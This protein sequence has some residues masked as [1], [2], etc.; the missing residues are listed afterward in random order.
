MGRAQPRAERD[1][2]Q[3]ASDCYSAGDLQCAVD[4]LTRALEKNLDDVRLRFILANALYRSSDALYRSSDF[5][6]AIQHYEEVL[7]FR[8]EHVDANLSLGFARYH[9]GD[10]QKA[11][12]A[13]RRALAL[14]PNDALAEASLAIGLAA[15]GRPKDARSHV[16]RAARLE[17]NWRRRLSID[18]RWTPEML[19]TL[20]SLMG[21]PAGASGVSF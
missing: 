4:I 7:R 18:I 17:P 13:W 5:E 16:E 10:F 20:S 2:A 6:K 8:P 14:M 9:N 12:L 19:E 15:E 21:E 3:R 1:A 11:V